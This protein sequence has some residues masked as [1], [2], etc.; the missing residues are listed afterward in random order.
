MG[1]YSTLKQNAKHALGGQW[2]RAIAIM[3]ISWIPYMLFNALEYGIRGAIGEPEYVG[4]N[5][6]ITVLSSITTLLILLLMFIVLTPVQQGVL[7]WYYRRTSGSDEPVSDLFYYF[8]AAGSY[9]K[10]LWL[11]F[12][13]GVRMFLWTILLAALPLTGTVI[14]GMTFGVGRGGR[15]HGTIALIMGLLTIV[16]IILL[17]LVLSIINM[18]YFLA[19]YLLAEHPDKKAS[20]L[21]CQSVKLTKGHKGSLFL[22]SLSFVGWLLLCIFIIPAFFVIPYIN[23]SMAMYAR[24]LI[25][26]GEGGAAPSADVTREYAYKPEIDRYMDDMST[27]AQEVPIESAEIP[28]QPSPISETDRQEG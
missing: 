26:L 20:R 2:G 12:Q 13:I 19:P 10:S 1:L 5:V 22:F 28:V 3:V 17:S 18:R 14:V 24:Y 7:R 16:W 15:L 8:E 27:P 21:I 6:N 4:G 23:I 11:H 9:F 25:Q